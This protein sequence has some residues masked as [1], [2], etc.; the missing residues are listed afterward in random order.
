[1]F[2]VKLEFWQ[3]N[4]S[5][6]L[7]KKKKIFLL[8]CFHSEWPEGVV[9]PSQCS[10][11]CQLTPLCENSL[12]FRI[13]ST[14]PQPISVW[15]PSLEWSSHFLSVEKNQK[16]KNLLWHVKIKVKFSVPIKFYWSIAAVIHLQIVWLPLHSIGRAKELEKRPFSPQS[17][18]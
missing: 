13:R 15:P 5:F 7:K 4:I 2:F 18:Q 17:L 11:L 10:A 14:N 9:D 8:R 12:N 3:I 6:L 16:K 1:M